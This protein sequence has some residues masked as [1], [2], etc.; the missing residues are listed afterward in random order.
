MQALCANCQAVVDVPEGEA[1][2]CPMCGGTTPAPL[3]QA[4]ERDDLPLS[5]PRPSAKVYGYVVAVAVVLGAAAAFFF[6]WDS[7]PQHANIL[8]YLRSPA[9][10]LSGVEVVEWGKPVPIKGAT[11][12]LSDDTHDRNDPTL[13]AQMETIIPNP[14]AF[15]IRVKYRAND[16][17]GAPVEGEKV[18][19]VANEKVGVAFDARDVRF[20]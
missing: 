13:W 11:V 2:A 4:F 9:R 12:F 8:Y 16:K 17:S 6:T 5:P 19:F 14:N 7:D 18:F 10:G 15:A 1:F 20:P 3:P